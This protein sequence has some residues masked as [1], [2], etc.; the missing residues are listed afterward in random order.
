MP[1]TLI[2]V[3]LNES[4]YKNEMV[5]NRWHPDI[6][7]ADMGQARR[8]LHHRDLRLDRRPHQEQRLRRRRARHRSDDRALPVRSDRREGRRAGRS[9]G[10]RHARHRRQAGQ[11]V[12]LQRL[13]LQAERRRLPDRPLPAGAE[14]DLGLLRHLHP[15]APRA[16]REVRRPDPSR[17][18]RLP[19]RSED[20]RHVEQ[21]R[22]RLHRHRPEPRAA[23]GG[24]AVRRHRPHGQGRRATPRPRPPRRAPARCRRANTAATATSR[25]C[26]AARRSTS[27]SM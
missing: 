24:A 2:K 12:G 6:P 5:H 23:A 26:R 22:R 9:A 19:A 18:D 15:F 3:D 25:I 13:L 14:V 16:G 7:M 1:E 11:P 27:P 8:R 17:P 20:A 21:A 4:P 10:R